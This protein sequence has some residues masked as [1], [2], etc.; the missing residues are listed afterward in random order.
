MFDYVIKSKKKVM[1]PINP[2]CIGYGDKLPLPLFKLQPHIA[3]KHLEDEIR[4][5][6]YQLGI[7]DRPRTRDHRLTLATRIA[8]KI[9]QEAGVE[10][11]K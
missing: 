7:T 4:N 8:I 11:W 5:C 2:N 6:A 1:C 10:E 9:A 3:F